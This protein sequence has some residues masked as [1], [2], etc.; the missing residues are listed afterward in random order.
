MIDATDL[1]LIAFFNGMGNVTSIYIFEN[2]IKPHVKK[3]EKVIDELVTGKKGTKQN[4]EILHK[5]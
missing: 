3:T 5:V 2:Y 4:E 1:M